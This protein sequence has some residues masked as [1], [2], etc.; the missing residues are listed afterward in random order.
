MIISIQRGYS[1]AIIHQNK[2]TFYFSV[3]KQKCVIN[4]FNVCSGI[5]CKN[6]VYSSRQL[7][8]SKTSCKS[9]QSLDKTRANKIVLSCKTVVPV[10]VSET[11]SVTA[12]SFRLCDKKQRDAKIA[13][14]EIPAIVLEPN[15]HQQINKNNLP[16][17]K[18]SE[19]SFNKNASKVNQTSDSICLKIFFAS[20][21]PVEN[22]YHC[23]KL[24]ISFVLKLFIK[25]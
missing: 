22:N 7:E 20:F 21:N 8:A 18:C 13:L 12:S 15:V 24:I 16:T 2:S 5:E 19:S 4:N 23:N 3:I 9:V 25:R 1:N 11:K 10:A 17:P 6:E 14:P